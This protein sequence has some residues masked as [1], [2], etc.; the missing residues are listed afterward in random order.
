MA[1]KMQM[2]VFTYVDQ[3][4]GNCQRVAVMTAPYH[5]ELRLA[6]IPDIAEDE[7]LIRMKYVGICG[8]DLEAYRGIRSPEFVSIPARLGHE[9]AGV[10]VKTG[11]KVQGIAEGDEDSAK[12][13]AWIFNCPDHGMSFSF[14]QACS[15]V[16][17]DPDKI[18]E[19]LECMY[20]DMVHAMM[21]GPYDHAR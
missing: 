3:D 7:V 11:S 15:A 21:E 18:R 2:P 20:P 13:F 12:Y 9:V 14:E 4:D 6:R 17:F 8:S 1:T 19:G 10:V 16:P 5:M